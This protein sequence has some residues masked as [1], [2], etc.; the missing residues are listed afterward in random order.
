[1]RGALP[2]L[3]AAAA[4]AG[5]LVSAATAVTR[6]AGR[7]AMA[8]ACSGHERDACC[9]PDCCNK[10]QTWR[11][12]CAG[13][14]RGPLRAAGLQGALHGAVGAGNRVPAAQRRGAGL[15]WH[16]TPRSG[17]TCKKVTS[18]HRTYGVLQL[19]A[20]A[21]LR[22]L[23]PRV[24]VQYTVP[25]LP[26]LLFPRAPSGACQSVG[27]EQNCCDEQLHAGCSDKTC[28]KERLCKAGSLAYQHS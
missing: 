19:G 7:L 23:K 11:S 9:Q 14:H 18:N 2:L 28:F 27:C 8:R 16:S 24:V 22:W 15:H 13:A 10:S 25:P 5:V 4:L 12:D 3:G 20:A 1:M 17:R 6:A 26:L 21:L